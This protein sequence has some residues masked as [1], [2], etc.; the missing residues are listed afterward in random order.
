MI[1]TALL[2]LLAT[3]AFAQDWHGYQ[4]REFTIDNARGYVVLPKIAAP[5]NPWLW[6]ARFP[7]YHPEYAVALLAKGFH[8]AYYDLP[9]IF[10]SPSAVESWDRFYSYVTATF[11]LSARPALEGVSRGGLF[12][13]NWAVKNPDKVSVI[14]CES[15]VCDI[16]SWPGGKGN[17]LG[18]PKDW[19]E[20]LNAYSL[21]EGQLLAWRGN[22]I[23]HAES[24]A[25][26]RI[27]ILHIVCERDQVVPPTENTLVFAA[28]YRK[29]GGPITVHCNTA[30]PETLNGHHFPLDDPALPVNF[31]LRHTPG[32]ESLAGS[33]LTPQGIEYFKLREGLRNSMI[34]F[35]KGGEA[36]VVFMGGSI[37]N[38]QGWRDLVCNSLR[39]RFPQTRFDCINAGIPS[40]GSTPGAFRVL[41]DA[42]G[43]GSVDLLFEEAAVNDDANGFSPLEQLRGMEGIVRHA[44]LTNPNIDIVLLHF[45]DPGKMQDYREGKTPTVIQSHEKVAAHYGI[46]SIDLAREVTER[47]DAG[48]FAWDKDFKDLHPSPFGQTV[49]HRSILRMLDAAWKEPP[50][51]AAEIRPHPLPALLDEKSYY[52][53]RLVDVSTV[54]RGEGW[55]LNPN[56]QP[57]DKTPTRPGFVNIPMLVSE[58]PGATA[59]FRFEGTAVGIFVAAG[60]DAGTVEFSTDGGEFRSLDL[61]TRWSPKLHIPWAC[62][63]DADLAPGA[64]EL[65]LR[66]SERRNPQ[67]T[68]TAVRVCHMLVN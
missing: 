5:G 28:R 25:A 57:V 48:E 46:P 52:H 16:K 3:L 36:R 7:D 27:P 66:I 24:L 39:N 41:R 49:Y 1:R 65:V 32:S 30:S 6:R 22:P 56:W 13:Y 31:I 58:S 33:G 9:N 17:G 29:A 18:S 68:G 45:V 62:V 15:P 10:G 43:K 55:I 37:T 2:V 47:V 42:F 44:R 60:P 4:K 34:R 35:S 61:F 64:H 26:R 54:E 38:M 51:P 23:D 14:Y 40:T 12:V 11:N 67:S 21:T 20:A 8:L 19:Q 50:A 59:R 63:L 53:G